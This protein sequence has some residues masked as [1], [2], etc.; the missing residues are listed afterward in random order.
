M[1]T[2]I[3]KWNIG[4]QHCLWIFTGETADQGKFCKMGFVAGAGWLADAAWDSW[5]SLFGIAV[6]YRA[7]RR[8][9]DIPRD[10]HAGRGCRSNE[11]GT[12]RL[13]ESSRG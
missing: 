3:G 7:G 9:G 4:T 2:T 10:G 5:R 8:A 12:A 13:M 6:L 1:K 11:N